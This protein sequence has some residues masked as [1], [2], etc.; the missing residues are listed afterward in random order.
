MSNLEKF[1]AI[2]GCGIYV[3]HQEPS[4]PHT[5]SVSHLFRIT[6]G[7]LSQCVAPPVLCATPASCKQFHPTTRTC[8]PNSLWNASLW[9]WHVEWHWSSWKNL[10]KDIDLIFGSSKPIFVM[11]WTLRFFTINTTLS[12]VSSLIFW[13]KWW[14]SWQ[15]FAGIVD[16]E[17]G[18]GDQGC[19]WRFQEL[20]IFENYYKKQNVDL[21]SKQSF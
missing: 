18:K 5:S 15:F 9:P 10:Y 14:N 12:F 3:L 16:M 20:K 11:F 7:N 8:S 1:Q 2:F 17:F 19:T 13:F 6:L 21:S 4:A